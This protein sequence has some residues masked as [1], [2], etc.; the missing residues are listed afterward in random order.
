V[1]RGCPACHV[2]IDKDTGKYT[3]PFEAQERAKARGGTHPVVAP[4]GTKIGP[5]DDVNVTVCLQCHASGTGAR[6]GKGVIAPWSLRDIV[7]PAHMSS[8]FFTLH[9]GGDC[10]T[11]HNVDGTGKWELLTLAVNVNDKGV[12]DP[13]KLPIP[14][15]IEIK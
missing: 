6:A 8:R 10:F 4:D 12:P 3:L 9:Y 14:G 13:S 15:A 2:L 11:C 5:T 1:S 7:H